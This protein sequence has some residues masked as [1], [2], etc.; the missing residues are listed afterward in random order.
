MNNFQEELVVD[1]DRLVHYLVRRIKANDTRNYEYDDLVQ[2]GRIGLIKAAK[3]YNGS[4]KFVTYAARCINNELLMFIR[5]GNRNIECVSMDT[6]IYVEGDD[7]KSTL[8]ETIETPNSDFSIL[9][10]DLCEVERIF[11]IVLNTLDTRE[12][13]IWLYS[14]LKE[15]QKK[16]AERFNTTQS[17]ISRLKKGIYRK[18]NRMLEQEMY[19]Q[20]K[21]HVNV[22]TNQCSICFEI[23]DSAK[24]QLLVLEL[25]KNFQNNSICN[26]TRNLG[27]ITITFLSVE[28]A[29][30]I[31][32]LIVDSIDRYSI[33][34]VKN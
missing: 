26:I 29:L 10:S 27:K 18:I 8:G 30:P 13:L 21:Y 2:I 17:Y 22:K 7:C 32:A 33:R 19:F 14:L 20:E 31:I 6:P 23:G 34:L 3:T 15:N 5:K 24:A 1:N 16:I 11:N 9:I 28:D 25:L 12:I 4:F